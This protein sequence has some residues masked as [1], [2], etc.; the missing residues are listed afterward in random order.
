[1]KSVL[2]PE[3]VV[4]GALPGSD[5]AVVIQRAQR[6]D[7]AAVSEIYA[8]YATSILRFLYARVNERE[9]AQDLTQEVF[10]RVIKSIGGFEY[11]DEKSF[12]AWLYT[13]AG[14]IL[15]S[16]YRRHNNAATPLDN[17]AHLQHVHNS[18]EVGQ[19]HERLALEEAMR[20][21]TEEQQRILSLRFFA[22]MS[23]GE[24]A[25]ALNRSEGSIKAIQYRALQSLQRILGREWERLQHAQAE[26]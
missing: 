4:A 22:D 11:R 23:N 1:M 3:I 8:R 18:D 20:Q 15:T 5:L 2:W 25:K 14:N 24:I 26:S 16:Y 7:V 6:K 12:L 13:I 21:L 19:L 10:I 17:P 9:L